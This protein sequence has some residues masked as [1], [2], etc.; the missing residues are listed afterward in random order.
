MYTAKQKLRTQFDLFMTSLNTAL[1]LFFFFFFSSGLSNTSSIGVCSSSD[2]ES[3]YQECSGRRVRACVHLFP[4]KR[5]LE[6]GDAT[7]E[8][9]NSW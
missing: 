7:L 5:S 4:G 1:V 9:C 3:K 6:V 2:P 8:S